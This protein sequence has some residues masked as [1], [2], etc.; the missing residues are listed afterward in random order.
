MRAPRA[1]GGIALLFVALALGCGRS[2]RDARGPVILVSIDTLPADRVGCYGYPSAR[3]PLL[4]RLARR[5]LQVRDLIS[6]APL[7]LP[8]H[9]TMLTG[10][11]P[12]VHGLRD[13]GLYRL[14]PTTPTLAELLPKDLPK[15]GFIGGF[16]LYRTFGLGRG[17][18]VWDDSGLAEAG[19]IRHP[20]RRA[21]DVLKSA[22]AWLELRARDSS[23]FVFAQLYDPH[24][25]YEAP[26]RWPAAA[27][28]AGGDEYDAEVAYVDAQLVRFTA[29][30]DE[31][32]QRRAV[33]LVTAD[34]GEALGSHGEPTHSNFVYD[35]TQRV[36]CALEGP[37][38]PRRIDPRQRRLADVAATVL[39]L[40]GVSPGGRATSLI[41][42]G[43]DSPAYVETLHTKLFK[44]WSALYGARTPQWKYIRA[45]RSELYDL[46]EDPGETRNLLAER[47]DVGRELSA[48]VDSA[49][50]GA[51]DHPA[52]GLSDDVR[53]RLAALGYVAT[54]PVAADSTPSMKDPKDGIAG[55]AALFR[56]EQAFLRGDLAKA[57]EELLSALAADPSLKDAHAYLAGVYLRTKRFDLAALHGET[58]LQLDPHVNET[59]M[60]ATLGEAYLDLGRSPDALRHLEIAAAA[61]PKDARLASLLQ[62][63]RA[64]RR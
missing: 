1:L 55:T 61:S 50:A 21:A 56:G 27:R 49:L 22:R 36:P 17:F 24:Y 42:E 14:S 32:F 44:G 2:P 11:D 35:A 43:E 19:A 57:E 12:P 4:D 39:D 26:A 31:T 58:A 40:Y 52:A 37:G 59:P 16:P 10:V 34:H 23:P 64:S 33:Y 15:A 41:R 18:D 5:G 25:P 48:F 3:T 29:W 63:A 7:T 51:E 45:P 62:R 20:Q 28:A 38:A 53:A 9:A 46:L 30:V 54:A 8:S 60:H 47:P 6:P 13:N